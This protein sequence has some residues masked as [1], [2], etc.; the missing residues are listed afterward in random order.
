[1]DFIVSGS[2][3]G[4]DSAVSSW[5]GD[6]STRPSDS[7]HCMDTGS[8][9]GSDHGPRV[10]APKFEGHL[11][12]LSHGVFSQAL[13]L[14]ALSQAPNLR[15]L[16]LVLSQCLLTGPESKCLLTGPDS[17]CLLTGTTE[18]QCLCITRTYGLVHCRPKTEE[19]G[20]STRY[21]ALQRSMTQSLP[22]MVWK[23]F[24]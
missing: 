9:N 18:P 21:Y 5:A 7:R 14:S 6:S 8:S 12:S 3:L 2:S 19:N 11:T 10:T 16:S 24:G 20:V 4:R 1:M 23:P 15:V 13:S 22:F 17:K